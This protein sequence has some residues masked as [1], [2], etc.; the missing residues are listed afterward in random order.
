MSG[1]GGKLLP[2]TWRQVGPVLCERKSYR[3]C[4]SFRELETNPCRSGC[5]W[6][7]AAAS[8]CCPPGLGPLA[9]L[10]IHSRTMT[11]GLV[12]MLCQ[13]MLVPR[14]ALISQCHAGSRAVSASMRLYKYCCLAVGGVVMDAA[15]HVA[16]FVDCVLSLLQ[17]VNC[18][19]VHGSCVH[20]KLP[21][22]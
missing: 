7:W 6:L 20:S 10:V 9:V 17:T 12:L 15:S 21:R 18:W 4:V 16:C 3:R 11:R 19:L 5:S 2:A 1:C 22:T 13:R 8:S 14:I